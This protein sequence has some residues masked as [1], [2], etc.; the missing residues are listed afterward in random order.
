MTTKKEKCPP[1][2]TAEETTKGI[3]P[4]L[5]EPLLTTKETKDILHV[6][7]TTLWRYMKSGILIPITV[8]GT[9]RYRISDVRKFFEMYHQ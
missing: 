4:T 9:N 5:L 3:S 8:G 2:R 1:K 7:T 6:S